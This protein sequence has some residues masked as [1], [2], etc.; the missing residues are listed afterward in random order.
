M[1]LG[2]EGANVK[3]YYAWT[4]LD[5]FE[6]AHGYTIRYGLTYVDF[7]NLDRHFKYSAYWYKTFLM[8]QRN[9]D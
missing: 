4:F 2:R 5:D 7:N 8:K 9:E 1:I 3:A 6:W